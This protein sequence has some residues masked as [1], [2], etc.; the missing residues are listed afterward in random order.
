MEILLSEKEK[1]IKEG[2]T[3]VFEIEAG[4]VYFLD[5]QEIRYQLHLVCDQELICFLTQSI[6]Y[7]I[8]LPNGLKGLIVYEYGLEEESFHLFFKECL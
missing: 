6:V 8:T 5:D 2:Y 3:I 4:E 7:R 1:A